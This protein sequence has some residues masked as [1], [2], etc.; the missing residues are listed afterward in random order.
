[1]QELPGF[2]G[3]LLLGLD[4]LPPGLYYYFSSILAEE[5]TALKLDFLFN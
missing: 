3:L 2:F 4:K 5:P 1:L